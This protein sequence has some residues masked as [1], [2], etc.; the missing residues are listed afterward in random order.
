MMEMSKCQAGW[1]KWTGN[2]LYG[3]LPGVRCIPKVMAA[4][5]SAV[6]TNKGSPR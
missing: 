6:T 1:P 4:L 2:S 5:A 3:D